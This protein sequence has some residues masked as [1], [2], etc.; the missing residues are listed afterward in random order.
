M[1][2]I[3]S[4][5]KK[6]S[7]VGCV[8]SARLSRSS[9]LRCGSILT[10][11]AFIM[12][13]L[14]LKAQSVEASGDVSPFP[15]P[16]PT[17]SLFLDS[18][19]YVG[20]TNSGTLTI[21]NGGVVS[22]S[23]IIDIGNGS[24]GSVT[25]SGSGS[26]FDS[27][28]LVYIGIGGGVGTLTIS[29]G[30]TASSEYAVVGTPGS[31]VTVTGAGSH[32]HVNDSIL[33][34][35]PAGILVEN[36]GRISGA[37]ASIAPGGNITVSGAN[38]RLEV[39]QLGFG[40]YIQN[41]D[42]Y[43][44]DGALVIKDGGAVTNSSAAISWGN[45][46]SVSGAG[47]RWE[48][49]NIGFSGGATIVSEGG[50]VSSGNI[51]FDDGSLFKIETGGKLEVGQFV[52]RSNGGLILDGGTLKVTESLALE[53]VDFRGG[54]LMSTGNLYGYSYRPYRGNI[55]ISGNNANWGTEW[56]D[57][58]AEGTL[59]VEDG[60]FVTSLQM[61][62]GGDVTVSGIG[63]KLESEHI[64]SYDGTFTIS[65]GGTVSAG[66]IN[67]RSGTSIITGE[68][69]ALNA[70]RIEGSG[71]N[72]V[73]RIENG[74]SVEAERIDLWGSSD[75]NRGLILDGG[76]LKITESAN[77]GA[78]NIRS[79]TL[80]NTGRLYGYSYQPYSG[81]IIISGSYAVWEA[82]QLH[83]GVEGK[84][85]TLRIE[86]GG[87]V[88]TRFYDPIKIGVGEDSVGTVTVTGQNSKLELD[89]EIFIGSEGGT[90]TLNIESGG[91]VVSNEYRMAT[92]GAGEGSTGTVVVKDSGSKLEAGHLNIGGNS[93]YDPVTGGTGTLRVEN[94]GLVQ[95][96][97]ASIGVVGTGVVTV[98]GEQSEWQVLGGGDL[99]VGGDNG[100]L[101]IEDGGR[102]VSGGGTVI[103]ESG[104]VVVRGHSSTLQETSSSISN[105]DY[106]GGIEVYGGSLQIEDGGTVTS[107]AG[108][109]HSKSTTGSASNVTVTG[110]G[111]E[112]S[113]DNGNGTIR[114]GIGNQYENTPGGSAIL[115]IADAG[116][117]SSGT[118]I[119]GSHG[120]TGT[121][122]VTGNGS[123]WDVGNQS[124]D[125]GADTQAQDPTSNERSYGTGTLI[126]ENGGYVSSASGKVGASHDSG[127]GVSRIS[128]GTAIVTGDN[129]R[130][131]VNGKLE[132]G[133]SYGQGTLRIENGGTVASQSASI[134]SPHRINAE[135]TADLST[136]TVTGT[137]SKWE[138][139]DSLTNNGILTIES[140]GFVSSNSGVVGT[141]T[142]YTPGP[143][144]I[145]QAGSVTVAGAN[146]EWRINNTLT[147][148]AANTLGTLTIVDRGKVV[149]GSATI[150]SPISSGRPE[151]PVSTVTV[152]G[153][154]S[155]W[156]VRGS[157]GIGKGG[158]VSGPP[159]VQ[160]GQGALIIKDGGRVT[161]DSAEITA[162]SVYGPRNRSYA[163]VS[164][165]DS[166][167][168]VNGDLRIGGDAPLNPF[169][170]ASLDVRDGGKVA[171]QG[172][173][174]VSRS[175][176]LDIEVSRSGGITV[177]QD[178]YNYG[179]IRLTAAANLAAGEYRPLYAQY[180]PHSGDGIYRAFGGVWNH[181]YQAFTVSAA[182]D[183]DSGIDTVVDLQETQRLSVIGGKSQIMV[184]FDAEAESVNGG[185]EIHF[186]ATEN[187]AHFIYGELVLSAWDFTTDM[188]Y[189]YGTLLAF[190]IGY[191]WDVDMLTIWHS[192]DGISWVA[193]DIESLYSDDTISFFVEGFSSYAL[194]VVPEPGTYAL[195]LS[196]LI[197]GIALY[198][199]KRS[200]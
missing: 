62:I 194:T 73:M 11:S 5:Y 97:S 167:W 169:N 37:S 83:V 164:G 121:V 53:N 114:V 171:V 77:M 100:T 186:T 138:I 184:S 136:V 154:G 162:N 153:V 182:Q 118:G 72:Y 128:R 41:G 74:G 34:M 25:V 110:Y 93:F 172:S 159:S 64:R 176:L 199:R 147:V 104:T 157:L 161:S 44:G 10:V 165:T 2:V 81:N 195:L 30:G 21:T 92:I 183:S 94:G 14:A 99:A 196:V 163:T 120:G 65:D 1:N 86:D 57:V 116:R 117:V 54:T 127:W 39:G 156:E 6:Q 84:E 124:I 75:S 146:S 188:D 107:K 63:S 3:F 29:D 132:I 185:S 139:N 168:N 46:V 20:K 145:S 38:S 87:T 56:I 122:I 181:D 59:R 198:R 52:G 106:S 112:W 95:S 78:V 133:S 144:P 43:E 80:L 79:G 8:A 135:N 13:P 9:L 4:H 90:G 160:G 173:L 175:G 36:G 89:T 197:G 50:S 16:N 17:E 119:I 113:I 103:G 137:G 12:L 102:V 179:V 149:S 85:S 61:N 35:S 129:S 47:S 31:S 180:G 18:R 76:S 108:S 109:I 19:F 130:W 70:E 68:G 126:V 96:G 142:N 91:A 22:S 152:A 143:Y 45:T 115:T 33:A 155:E 7:D 66:D 98:T 42:P 151:S 71:G 190:S 150:N 101:T 200:A 82:E 58:G 141:S 189:G 40:A 148:G 174:T 67:L 32:W 123:Q 28:S 88:A 193:M 105:F 140:G 166:R 60:G 69:S 51:E 192:I 111:S 177:G 170:R 49:V 158:N 125:I 24:S 23:T 26:R 178:V 15:D 55:I 48:A 27:T 134:Q 191:G 187:N 131:D